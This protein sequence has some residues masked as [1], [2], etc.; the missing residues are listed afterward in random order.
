MLGLE[1]RILE[2][3]WREEVRLLHFNLQI[4]RVKCILNYRLCTL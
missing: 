3:F 1:A 2:K 4:I